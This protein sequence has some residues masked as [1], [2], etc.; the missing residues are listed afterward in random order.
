MNIY[1]NYFT[2][3]HFH[4]PGISNRGCWIVP[5]GNKTLQNFRLTLVYYLLFLKKYLQMS[6]RKDIHQVEDDS[7]NQSV[8]LCRW[9]GIIT[10]A[11]FLSTIIISYYYSHF[12]SVWSLCSL[13]SQTKNII[14]MLVLQ[15]VIYYPFLFPRYSKN[16]SF[17]MSGQRF[18]LI[19]C[20]NHFVDVKM[21]TR[22]LQTNICCCSKNSR[23]NYELFFFG[24]L[25]CKGMY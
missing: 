11:I 17:L 6:T 12:K 4:D 9:F 8:N 2:L 25:I 10:V 5:H 14:R 22:R 7:I 19:V 18:S 3:G 20:F 1:P 21:E 24:M 13:N 23:N 16:T 15:S